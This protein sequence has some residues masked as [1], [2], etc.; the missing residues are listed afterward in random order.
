MII[1]LKIAVCFPVE[2]CQ[3][4]STFS[5]SPQVSVI[6]I[7]GR[8][9]RCKQSFESEK[10]SLQKTNF[11][12]RFYP[13]TMKIGSL[14]G[15]EAA[16]EAKQDPSLRKNYPCGRENAAVIAKIK[17]QYS[18]DFHELV[19]KVCETALIDLM[20]N[21][22]NVW[23]AHAFHGDAVALAVLL[24]ALYSKLE[25]LY[26]YDGDEE[27]WYATVDPRETDSW[28]EGIPSGDENQAGMGDV[29][30]E[31]EERTEDGK[32]VPWHVKG[33]GADFRSLIA[34]AG[35]GRDNK[36]RIFS[37]LKNFYLVGSEK[38]DEMFGDANLISLSIP[39]PSMRRVK[40]RFVRGTSCERNHDVRILRI[41]ELDLDRNMNRHR[42][43][44][45]IEGTQELEC[46]KYVFETPVSRQTGHRAG[47]A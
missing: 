38:V 23:T 1:M 27:Y 6:T 43:I 17:N 44:D 28:T 10:G 32:K 3:M 20:K 11:G 33:W 40:G 41:T 29:P 16:I 14:R 35:A 45:L 22:L 18:R 31:E 9:R 26:I 24:L 19:V 5:L 37:R 47:E 7:Y 4:L 36:M 21:D 13:H 30:F 15:Y 34:S 46:F 12:S 25:T 39:L 2:W 8:L 42:L